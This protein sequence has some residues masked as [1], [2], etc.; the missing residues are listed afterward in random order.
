MRR[1]RARA[2]ALCLWV[3]A[4]SACTSSP[5]GTAVDGGARFD[6]STDATAMTDTAAVDGA[7]TDAAPAADAFVARDA[8]SPTDAATP[9]DAATE[10]PPDAVVATDAALPFLRCGD[11]A[12]EGAAA[13]PALPTYGGGSC[14]ALVPGRNT[15]TSGGVSRQF[16]LIVP[17]NLQPDEHPPLVFLWHWLGGSANAFSTR[18]MVQD[19]ANRK[20]FIAIIPEATN[21]QFKWP[22]LT[23]DPNCAIDFGCNCDCRYQRELTFFDD[24]LACVG[25]AYSIDRSC[26]ATVGVSA[27]A[28]WSSQLMHERS[29]YLSS[30]LILSGGTGPASADIGGIGFGNIIPVREYQSPAEHRLPAMVLWGGPSDFC[31][32]NFQSASQ[33]LERAL[34]ADGHFLLECIHNCAHSVPPFDAT[35]ERAT[36]DVLWDFVLDHPYWLPAGT[37]PYQSRGLPT[38]SPSWCAIGAGNAVIRS[39]MCESSEIAPGVNL[40]SCQ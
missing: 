20:R 27:G 5:E 16:L 23:L 29:Q 9:V 39:G 10:A 4:L 25:G 22:F 21:L 8:F 36:F 2:L 35:G 6:G 17:E 31:L 12:P 37:S 15:I 7:R 3:S 28:L 32:L 38:G 30:A 11:P 26:V 18:A 19:G 24:V 13:P 1:D 14:P 33:N 40:G 34:T